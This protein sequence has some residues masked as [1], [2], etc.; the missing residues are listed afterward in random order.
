M[1]DLV[2]SFSPLYGFH[3]FWQSLSDFHVFHPVTACLGSSKG[4]LWGHD[5]WFYIWSNT[6]AQDNLSSGVLVVYIQ[7][8]S[9]LLLSCFLFPCHLLTLG[10]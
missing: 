4:T 1:A 6:V 10:L 9:C 8:T 3:A 7:N 5:P 2:P